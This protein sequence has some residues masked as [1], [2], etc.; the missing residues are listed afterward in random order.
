MRI[1]TLLLLGTIDIQSE[2][3]SEREIISI[4]EKSALMNR[5]KIFQ[6]KCRH[7]SQNV[8]MKETHRGISRSWKCKG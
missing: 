1:W 6:R 3:L 5:M 7:T 8:H 2:E 4:N